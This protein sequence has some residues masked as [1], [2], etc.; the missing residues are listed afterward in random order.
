MS[1]AV[2][3]PGAVLPALF[4]ALLPLAPAHA[5]RP[6]GGFPDDPAPAAQNRYPQFADEWHTFDRPWTTGTEC[7]VAYYNHCTGWVWIWSGAP[8][9]GWWHIGDRV[10]V[11]VESCDER[12]R[13]TTTWTYFYSAVPYF[14]GYTGV[15]IHAVDASGCPS[16]APLAEQVR[17]PL[18]GWNLMTWD[19][20][21]PGRFAIVQELRSAF[22]NIWTLLTTDHP[23]AG[24]AAPPACGACYPPSRTTRSWYWG[25]AS[26]PRCPGVP[27]FDGVCNAEFL[28]ATNLEATVGVQPES[29]GSIKALYR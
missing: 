17:L 28:V 18:S 1:L 25:T 22:A 27:F 13:L 23:A 10:G 20:E 8:D 2:R 16:G 14:Y 4:V 29:W 15:A 21:V 19:V 3:V 26:A 11:V 9:A 24:G 5:L 12:S 7:E 6:A